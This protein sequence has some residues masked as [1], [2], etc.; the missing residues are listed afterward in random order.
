MSRQDLNQWLN[1]KI[2]DDYLEIWQDSFFLIDKIEQN[3]TMNTWRE[4]DSK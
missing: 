4:K 2:Q 1:L 3:C